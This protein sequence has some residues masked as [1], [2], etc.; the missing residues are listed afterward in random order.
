M[1]MMRMM[2]IM[3]ATPKTG[4]SV[5]GESGAIDIINSVEGERSEV[6]LVNKSDYD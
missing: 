1:M 5:A 2:M 4:G 3:I 6:Q